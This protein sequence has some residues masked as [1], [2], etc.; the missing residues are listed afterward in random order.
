MTEFERWWA[1]QQYVPH[2]FNK[3]HAEKVWHAA[4]R[5]LIPIINDP[6]FVPK[7]GDKVRFLSLCHPSTQ[8]K[9]KE[10]VNVT[11]DII[12]VIWVG[13]K[14]KM[15]NGPEQGEEY[16]SSGILAEVEKVEDESTKDIKV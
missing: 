1:R 12:R 2:N 6:P 15:E 9:T 8:G 11:E 14:Y 10:V 7:V 5:A 13:T 4:Q 16:F 3:E